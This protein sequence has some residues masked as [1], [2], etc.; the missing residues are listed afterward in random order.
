MVDGFLELRREL[1]HQLDHWQTEL[2]NP[3]TRF[4]NWGALLDAR[5]TLQYL[6]E[7]C[8]DQRAAI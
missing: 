4:N 5:L 2:L 8:E 6:D 1:T 3:R 7:V